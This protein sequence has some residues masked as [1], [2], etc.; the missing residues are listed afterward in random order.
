[1]W[2]EGAILPW[3]HR[4]I[5]VG[6]HLRPFTAAARSAARWSRAA[7][8]DDGKP[9]ASVLHLLGAAKRHRT[10]CHAAKMAFF[11][12][13]TLVPSTVAVGSALG[14]SE[15]LIG[16][17]PVAETERS[18]SRARARDAEDVLRVLDDQLVTNAVAGET[19]ERAV[20]GVS[21]KAPEPLVWPVQP[22]RD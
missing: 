11:A 13:L 12:V 7:H 8:V 10:T 6:M 5:I 2:A 15:R 14:L 20:V 19:I 4:R 9:W 22:G 18:A 17:E 1:M 21:V 16:P 3:R